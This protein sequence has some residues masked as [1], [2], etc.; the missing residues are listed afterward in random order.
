MNWLLLLWWV[1]ATAAG[2]SLGSLVELALGRSSGI[3]VLAFVAV[4]GTG[5]SVLQWLALRKHLTQVG[6]WVGTGVAA[7]VVVG[8][9]GLAAG[10]AA[11][12]ATVITGGAESGLDAGL[13]A[14]G[15]TAAVL[16]GAALG[17]VQW[18]LL[19]W[20]V[21]GAGW[22]VLACG[23]GW[24]AGGFSAGVTDTAAGWAVLGAVYGALTGSVLVWLLRRRVDA[25]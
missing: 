12:I 23:V 3:T 24:V 4:G 1:L 11:A 20:Q 21:A 14:A 19:R 6:W 7:S 25:A 9:V 17:G 2:F 15:V 5:A 13:D 8:V 22:W 10:V 18:V 16:F